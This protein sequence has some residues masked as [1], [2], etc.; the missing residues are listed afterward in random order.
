MTRLIKPSGP[1]KGSV[2]FAGD[3]SISHRALIFGALA[4]GQ[5]VIENL[6]A[7]QDVIATLECL[8]ALGADIRQGDGLT[9]VEGQGL[10]GF[11]APAGPLDAKNSATSMRLLM[12]LL[13]GQ[14]FRS[15]LTGDAS[16]RKRPMKRVA[17]PL[18]KMGARIQLERDETAPVAI[19]GAE[20]NGIE[21]S[22][23]VASAQLK[24]AVLLAG[25]LA[26]GET[27][28][29]E[30]VPSRDHT[31][32]WLR[33]FGAKLEISAA[34]I[35][36]SGGQVLQA[37]KLKVPGDFSSA[38]FWLAAAALSPG[39][40]LTVQGVVLNPTRVGFLRLLKQ[41][42]GQFKIAFEKDHPELVGSITLQAAPL[43]AFELGAGDVPLVIDEI[44]LL[45]LMATQARG[46]SVVK[47]ARELRI[48]E[49]DRIDAVAKL[50]AA[51]GGSIEVFSDGFAVSGPQK[52]RGAEIDSFGDHRIAM[53]AA[54]AGLIAEGP[55]A[56]KDAECVSIS[57]PDFFD[58]L[59]RLRHD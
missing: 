55:T 6:A 46:T 54:V 32:I 58:V 30:P 27:V 21:Y 19:E 8:R 2:S 16:L 22:M 14:P 41:M 12:G 11:H 39:S 29:H 5:T 28:V 43:S 4:E 59:D 18:Q 44:P 38:A 49:T 53:T 52:L 31:E 33:Y 1:L 35:A 23:P 3:K 56:V 42:G 34:T 24:S 10:Q 15:T 36:V 9:T 7:S 51:M 13:A 25:L 20:L 17:I 50:I 40:E 26:K 48:K 45:A 47:G 57:Y 37:Q